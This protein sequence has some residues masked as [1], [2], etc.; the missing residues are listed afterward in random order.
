MDIK[1]ILE[2]YKIIPDPLKDQFFL[3]DEETIKEMVNL[4]DL[5]KNDVVL[6]IGA[7][8]GNLTS[9]IAQKA[10]KVI[11]FEIDPQFK[12]FLEGLPKNVEVHLENAWEFV[13]LH[14]KI[15]QKKIYNKIVSNLPFSFCEQFLH[16]LAFLDYD[17]VIL[18]VPLKFIKT[19]KENPI[20]SSFFE[21]EEKMSVVKNKFYPLP[22]TN[23]A[24]IEL[25]KLPD[26]IETK[27]LPL[28]LRQYLYQKEPLKVKN[29]LREGL[30]KFVWL[31]YQ[32][33]L[34]KNQ[35]RKIIAQSGID[36]K[37]LEILPGNQIYQQL[38]R[39][40]FLNPD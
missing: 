15:R 23:S 32:K 37:L 36:K 12:P 38:D 40:K 2:K 8:V 33:R 10:G 19:I 27:N 29:S 3:T 21:V 16:N 6:E 28:F 30:I 9:E 20:F 13:K 18:L 26:P 5:N 7:G 39:I 24:V 25:K 1:K 22:R 35:A 14:G 31:V 17:K 34:T 4:A 11:A